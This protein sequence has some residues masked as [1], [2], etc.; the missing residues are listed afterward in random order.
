MIP[1]N[2]F[3]LNPEIPEGWLLVQRKDGFVYLMYDQDGEVGW[4]PTSAQI[5]FDTT[6]RNP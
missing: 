5:K 1:E 3:D 6:E 4:L 2:D